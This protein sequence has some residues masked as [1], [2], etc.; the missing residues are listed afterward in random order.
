M[1]M[2]ENFNKLYKLENEYFA[3]LGVKP[4]ETS[5]CILEGELV[6]DFVKT[7]NEMIE[8]AYNLLTIKIQELKNQKEKEELLKKQRQED[9][10]QENEKLGLCNLQGSE[11]QVNW[12]ND[13][14]KKL[15]E[16]VEQIKNESVQDKDLTILKRFFTVENLKIDSLDTLDKILQYIL[17]TK[18]KATYYIDNRSENVFDILVEEYKNMQK[19]NFI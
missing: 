4:C 8:T 9:I 17:S 10:K 2:N 11:K 16:K 3:L 5:R 7:N 18:Q 6:K 19:D 12:A 1:T 14:R 15:I 13:L